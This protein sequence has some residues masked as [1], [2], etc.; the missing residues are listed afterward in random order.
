MKIMQLEEE[1]FA[2]NDEKMNEKKFWGLA[3]LDDDD[4]FDYGRDIKKEGDYDKDLEQKL[5]PY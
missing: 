5:L 2:L 1:I 4:D 3:G